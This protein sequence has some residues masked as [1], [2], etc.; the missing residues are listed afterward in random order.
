MYEESFSYIKLWRAMLAFSARVETSFSA[1]KKLIT[2]EKGFKHID[3]VK[4]FV[5]EAEERSSTHIWGIFREGTA[6]HIFTLYS[7]ILG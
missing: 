4:A 5:E 7:G 3:Q 6:R 2:E 1:M